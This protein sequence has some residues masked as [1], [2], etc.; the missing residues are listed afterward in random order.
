MEIKGSN[1]HAKRSREIQEIL[2]IPE[3]LIKF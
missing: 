3:M 2:L 1:R